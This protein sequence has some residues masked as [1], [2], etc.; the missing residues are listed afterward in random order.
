MPCLPAIHAW[1]TP[2]PMIFI[3]LR[4]WYVSDVIA[5]ASWLHRRVKPCQAQIT[6]SWS[7]G[8]RCPAVRHHTTHKSNKISWEP[9]SCQYSHA[10]D[11]YGVEAIWCRYVHKINQTFKKTIFL[12]FAGR[13][14]CFSYEKQI[15]RPLTICFSNEKQMNACAH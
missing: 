14:A 9:L 12:T 3:S 15:S 4:L 5:C 7:R 10:L 13:P 6:N 8:E 1:A 11:N 2:C